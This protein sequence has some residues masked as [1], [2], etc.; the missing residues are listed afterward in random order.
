MDSCLENWNSKLVVKWKDFQG[1]KSTIRLRCGSCLSNLILVVVS[2][3]GLFGRVLKLGLG[4][5]FRTQ[6]KSPKNPKQPLDR[7]HESLREYI[8]FASSEDVSK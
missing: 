2:F 4:L 8:N 1:E 7:G 3:F 6:P 5:G